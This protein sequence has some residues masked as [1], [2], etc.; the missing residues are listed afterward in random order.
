MIV[1]GQSPGLRDG[2]PGGGGFS[3]R[4]PDPR[5]HHDDVESVHGP[6]V[7]RCLVVGEFG[8]SASESKF[9]VG[10][11]FRLHQVSHLTVDGGHDSGE[12]FGHCDLD[13]GFDECFCH[14]ESHVPCPDHQGP[15]DL[16]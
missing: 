12:P 7:E 16:S 2:G 5:C 14:L 11:G 3:R 9:H 4:C 13:A 15:G 10:S 6:V 1:D 8:Q